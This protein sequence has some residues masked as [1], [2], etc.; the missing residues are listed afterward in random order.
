M[1]FELAFHHALEH[2]V[3]SGVALPDSPDPVPDAVIE[4]LHPRERAYAREQ[5][6]Y[7]QVSFVGGRLAARAAANQ[8]G[9]MLGALLPDERG[10][11]VW[12]SGVT[13]SISHKRKLAVALVSRDRG[14]RL[15]VDLEEYEPARPTIAAKVLTPSEL[16][17]IADLPPDRQW[18]STVLRFTVKEAIYKALDPTVRRYIAFSEATVIPDRRGSAYV[19]MN[20]AQGEGPF[21]IE[22]R[23]AWLHGH[24]LATVSAV[25]GEPLP[26]PDLAGIDAD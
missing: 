23:Y 6:G 12:P 3:V 24:I 26:V 4:T 25:A 5:K 9:V 18:I 16:S 14:H 1:S 11:P 10:T 19:Q 13:G 17:A 20:L 7:R 21:C 2:G 22:A 8:L 15:G